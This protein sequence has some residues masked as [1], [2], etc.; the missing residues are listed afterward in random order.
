MDET[1]NLWNG[2]WYYEANLPPSEGN[3]YCERYVDFTKPNIRELM[4]KRLKTARDAG[5]DGVDPDNIDIAGIKWNS[6]YKGP[7]RHE[8]ELALLDLAAFAQGMNSTYYTNYRFMIGQKNAGDMAKALS[9]VFDFAVLERALVKE[10][11]T[12]NDLY[13]SFKDYLAADKPVIDIEYPASLQNPS[14]ETNYCK[15]TRQ[16]C[17]PTD[18]SCSCWDVDDQVLKKMD[19][20]QKLDYNE[21]GLNGCTQYC[22]AGEK[23]VI[24]P[25]V[26]KDDC[27]DK[28]DGKCKEDEKRVRFR[29]CE[30]EEN[31]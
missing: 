7:T 25:T 14:D 16:N 21:Y 10:D 13:K 22:G 3:L 29:C 27:I 19:R 23:V 31:A 15:T 20:V 8:V 5:C 28:F 6:G 18:R 4:K 30:C 12:P 24:T 9:S 2:P 11:G 17:K 1:K 26:P